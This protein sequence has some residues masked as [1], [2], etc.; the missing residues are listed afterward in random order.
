M[1]RAADRLR[2]A[3][4][5]NDRHVT[6]RSAGLPQADLGENQ[7]RWWDRLKLVFTGVRTRIL[8][9]FVVLVAFVLLLSLFLIRQVLHNRLDVEIEQSLVL[10]VDELIS[11]AGGNDPNTAQPFAGDVASIFDTFLKRNLPAEGEALYTLIGGFPY[12]TSFSAPYPLL[13]EP[14][15]V[16][17]WAAVPDT[18]R[19][20]ISTPEGPARY[21]AVAVVD[22]GQVR[23][24]FVVANFPAWEQAEIDSALTDM[25]MVSGSVLLLAALLAWFSAGRVL[26]PVRLLTGM[27]RSVSDTDLS[28]RIPEQGSDEIAVLTSNFNRMLDRL[29]AAFGSQRRFLDD[30]SHELR[31]PITIIR[32][33]LELMGPDPDDQRETLGIVSD[34][35]D[36]VERFVADL[37][38]LAKA[39]RPDFLQRAPFDVGEFT[40]DLFNK[41]QVLASRQWVLEGTGYGVAVAD[42]ARLTQAVLNLA[43]NSTHHTKD[44]D[45]IAIGSALTGCELSLWVRDIGPGIAEAEQPRLFERFAR[46]DNSRRREDGAGLGLAIVKSIAEA[47]G[48]RVEVHSQAGM[49]S[50]FQVVVPAD[51]DSRQRL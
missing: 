44:G 31:T 37:L 13:D 43:T 46:G 33:H 14:E 17:R 35:L 8:A 30:V 48:G 24:H 20:V 32:G 45:L 40:Q 12:K 21:L 7:A 18:E 49:G 47:H 41:A 3:R 2:F 19:G 28:R 22:A 5:G 39:E 51:P 42:R 10:E 23:G 15:V 34:E 16:A 6:A 11:L 9:W 25:A 26:A 50:T 4:L 38:L 29:E 27:T 1:M 36:R